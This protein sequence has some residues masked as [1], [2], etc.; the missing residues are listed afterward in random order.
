MTREQLEEEVGRL[1]ETDLHRV[2]DIFCNLVE[3]VNAGILED[4][5]GA[6]DVIR[7]IMRSPRYNKRLMDDA[8]DLAERWKINPFED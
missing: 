5:I 7:F 6:L 8:F 1:M 2:P 3:R 4:P